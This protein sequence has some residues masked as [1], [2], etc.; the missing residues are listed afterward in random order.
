[1][2]LLMLEGVDDVMKE[3]VCQLIGL[4]WLLLMLMLSLFFMCVIQLWIL[5]NLFRLNLFLLVMWVQ[6][7]S[8][9]LVSVSCFVMMKLCDNSCI[10]IM[11]SV[12]CFWV[13]RFG[14]I[15]FLLS[16]LQVFWNWCM[17]MVGLWLYCFQNIYLS[18]LVML[19]LLFGI[20]FDF[21]VRWMQI[22]LDW[23]RM[24]LFWWIRYGIWLVGLIDRKFLV[25]VLFLRILIFC[26]LQ[27]MFR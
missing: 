21:F 10:F 13:I 9:I 3:L 23:V 12:C 22:V 15:W 20:S 6:V 7:I 5:R 26:Q 16:F 17:V 19:K 2:F 4:K 18:I 1:M 8:V 14:L 25:C 24:W 27:L 11:L